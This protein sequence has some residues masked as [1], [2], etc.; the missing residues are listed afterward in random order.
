MKY[1]EMRCVSPSGC[2]TAVSAAKKRLGVASTARA[3]SGA[4]CIPVPARSSAI[5]PAVQPFF[6]LSLN[7]RRPAEPDQGMWSILVICEMA[8][9]IREYPPISGGFQVR[10][11]DAGFLHVSRI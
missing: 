1:V 3:S 2:V 7:R 9:R 8:E 11:G 4:R 10:F 6:S 5:S